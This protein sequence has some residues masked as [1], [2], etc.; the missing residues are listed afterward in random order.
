[1]T[2]NL[3]KIGNGMHTLFITS[4]KINHTLFSG[5]SGCIVNI[6]EYPPRDRRT[7]VETT[8]VKTLWQWAN[9]NAAN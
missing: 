1:M 2:A 5:S 4:S 8:T 6:E 7:N 9:N 3:K